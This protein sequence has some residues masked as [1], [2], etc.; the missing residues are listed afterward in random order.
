M[1][2]RFARGLLR[3]V[4]GFLMIMGIIA[5]ICALAF[6]FELEGYKAVAVFMAAAFVF[7]EDMWM[8]YKFGR[9]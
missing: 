2:K 7:I 8:I 5:S 6:V 9:R 4:L 3:A 1:K